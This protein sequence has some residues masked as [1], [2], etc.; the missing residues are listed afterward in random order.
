MK[1]GEGT[2]AVRRSV[3]PPGAADAVPA[4]AHGGRALGVNRGRERNGGRNSR[5]GEIDVGAQV[6]AEVTNA[7]TNAAGARCFGGPP[8]RFLGAEVARKAPVVRTRT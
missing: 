6:R 5:V 3:M 7:G 8:G 4:V 1:R 2:E